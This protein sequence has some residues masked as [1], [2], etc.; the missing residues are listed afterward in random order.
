VSAW[1]PPVYRIEIDF[2][3]PLAFAYRWCTDY[4]PDDA[5]LTGDRFER[6]IVRRT[7][8]EVVYEDLWWEPD[9]WRWR[10]NVVALHPPAF[11]HAESVGNVR[12]ASLDYR[13][14]EL[15][16]GR[17]RLELV[18]RRRPVSYR[19]EQPSR[20]VL[21]AELRQMWASYARLMR[22]EYLR[23]RVRKTASKARSR[24]PRRSARR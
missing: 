20:R 11:W 5:R 13:L 4:R 10:R 19:P 23:S 15:P 1:P 14:T 7:R 22:L 6:R 18:M 16:G 17:C 24:R 21:E 2:G 9:G 8:R 12:H 3:V